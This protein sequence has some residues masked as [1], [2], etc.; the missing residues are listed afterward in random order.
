[1]LLSQARGLHAHVS[2]EGGRSRQQCAH[3]SRRRAAAEKRGCCWP[4]GSSTPLFVVLRPDRLQAHAPQAQVRESAQCTAT[5]L[6]A[7]GCDPAPAE[8]RANKFS[9][10]QVAAQKGL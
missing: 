3:R 7:P 6:R 1:M 8:Q 10:L 4:Q 2:H 5:A 9:C